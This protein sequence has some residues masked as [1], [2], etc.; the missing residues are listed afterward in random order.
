MILGAAAS[1]Y[2]ADPFSSEFQRFSRETIRQLQA[3]GQPVATADVLN[4]LDTVGVDD[5]VSFFQSNMAAWTPYH[6]DDPDLSSDIRSALADQGAQV[7]RV[8]SDHHFGLLS[9]DFE[10]RVLMWE[11]SDGDAELAA[12]VVDHSL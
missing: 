8:Y 11:K 3:D 6:V 12:Y 9:T 1:V 5:R 7:L 4:F 2:A 10:L